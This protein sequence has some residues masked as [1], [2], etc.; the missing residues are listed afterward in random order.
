MTGL[1]PQK[2]LTEHFLSSKILMWIS[3]ADPDPGSR[4]GFFRIPDPKPMFLRA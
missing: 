2:F 4:I 1:D 3:V